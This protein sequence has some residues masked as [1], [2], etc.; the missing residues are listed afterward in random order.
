[1]ILNTEKIVESSLSNDEFFALFGIINKI[2]ISIGIDSLLQKGIIG[3]SY[4][5]LSK[6][7]GFFPTKEG[8]SIYTNVILNSENIKS[9]DSFS[10][11]A[12]KLKE[13][14]PKGR[15]DGTNNPWADSE[16]LICKRLRVFTKKYGEFS[17]D[18]IVKAT[19]SYI[20]SFNGSY[21]IMR[22]LRYFIFKE[23]KIGDTIEST[24]DL[25]NF[26][27]NKEA[28]TLKNDWTSTIN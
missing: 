20:D 13:L 1:M 8:L 11:L 12:K 19:K 18:D 9:Q 25:L 16:I 21:A 27:E 15:K 26:L 10:E 28:L 3:N 22:T 7:D 24:S 6:P 2:D 17:D 14:F 4:N 5:S 23:T